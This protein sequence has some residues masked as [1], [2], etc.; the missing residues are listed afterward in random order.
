MK[1]KIVLVLEM[2]KSIVCVF[3]FLAKLDGWILCVFL[4]LYISE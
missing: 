2:K 1:L 3:G 4:C